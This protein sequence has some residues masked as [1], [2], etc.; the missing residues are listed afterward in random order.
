MF[1]DKYCAAISGQIRFDSIQQTK[2]KTLVNYMFVAMKI[3]ASKNK[4]F[5]KIYSQILF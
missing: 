1:F 5:I 4:L 2:I 3:R